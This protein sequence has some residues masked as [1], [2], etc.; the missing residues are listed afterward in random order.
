MTDT[1]T[2]AAALSRRALLLGTGSAGLAIGL[3]GR[4]DALYTAMPDAGRRGPTKGY[5]PL[6]RDPR[7]VLDLPRGFSYRILSR[8]GRPMRSG[9]GPVP[10]NHDGMGSFANRRG[11]GFRL[12]RNHEVYPDA[13]FRV[14][15]AGLETTYDPGAGGG[16]TNLVL[17][18]D[19]KLREEY[20]SLGGTAINCSGGI[21]PWGTWLTCEETEDRTGT[22]GYTKDHGWIFE[23]DPYDN[24]R[25]ADPVPLTDMGRFMHEAV[26]I[27][28]STGI[29]YETEDAF[30]GAPLGSYYRFL[31]HKPRGGYGSLRAGGTLQALHVPGLE[32]LSTV[33][34]AG[35]TFRG[36]EW[37]DVPDPTAATTPTRAQDYPKPITRG[38]KLEG[39]WWGRADSSSYFVS[40]FARPEDGSTASHDGQVWRYDTRRNTLTLELIFVGTDADDV[41]ECPDNICVSPYG[42]L[43]ICEDSD[44]ENYMLGTTAAGEPFVFARNRQ[45]TTPGNTG[46]LSGVSFSPDGRVM[47]FNVYDPGTTFAV[48]G[49]WRRRGGRRR[50]GR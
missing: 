49:P 12:V 23:V 41:Y 26:A 47:F 30:S 33:R 14:P 19:L 34:K 4:A 44:G 45:A 13:E 8:E 28:P 6:V 21:T 22:N 39:A 38:Q 36:I 3:S 27:D 43:M 24:R 35:T 42:G 10:S 31:P 17:G 9:G 11:G 37:L 50:G 5:G 18:S 20:V 29:A 2:N 32:D 1:Q 46:E 16:T 15:T 25:N 7:G 48:T 40:S